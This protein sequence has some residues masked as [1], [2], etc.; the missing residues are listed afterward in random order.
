MDIGK[1]RKDLLEFFLVYGAENGLDETHVEKLERILHVL[2][3]K[4]MAAV[5]KICRGI[6]KHELQD[7]PEDEILDFLKEGKLA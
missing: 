1:N 3:P 7:L 5:K 2:K 6:I 4:S